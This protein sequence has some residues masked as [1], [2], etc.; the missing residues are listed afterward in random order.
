MSIAATSAAASAAATTT[1]S[2]STNSLTSLSDNFDT[3]LNLLTT[4]LK[5]QD[6]TSPVD[7]N[8]FTQQLVEFSGVQQQTK[9]NS[10]L[11]KL[12][13]NT[14][15][16]QVGSASS[17][18]GTT[19]RANGDKGALTNGV[20][21]FGYTLPQDASAVNVSIINATGQVV[22]TGT[23]ADKSGDNHVSWDGKNSITGVSEADGTYTIKVSAK[24]SL[25]NSIK[26]TPFI[27]GT[28][29]SASIANG[30]VV[31]N[32]GKLEVPQ[33]SVISISNLKS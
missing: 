15:V 13:D 12:V 17:F 21:T 3:F 2:N 23:G 4:Q 31:L 9:T 16:S 30:T 7:S 32:I 8:Q 22:F 18:I 25:G 26:A 29:D 24:D 20:A 28:V 6:P 14:Q 1:G 5:N 19:I 27:T 10:L 11:Q 33:T